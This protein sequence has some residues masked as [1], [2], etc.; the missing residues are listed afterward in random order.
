[1]LSAHAEKPEKAFGRIA[2]VALIALP[3]L[4]PFAEGPSVNA[5]QQLATWACVAVLSGLAPIHL[6]ARPLITWLAASALAVLL[7]HG[8]D[9]PLAAATVFALAMAGVAACVGAGMARA[10]SPA[11]WA[12]ALLAAGLLSAPL[13]LLQYYGLADVLVPWTT[14]PEP[15]QAYGNLRQRNQFASLISMALIAALWLH[16]VHGRRVRAALAPGALLLVVAA[17]AATSRTGLLVFRTPWSSSRLCWPIS[18]PHGCCPSWPV[19]R[20]KACWPACAMARRRPTA[21]CCYGAT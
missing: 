9:I 3:F 6:P 20:S 4:L 14:T 2:F 1:M 5:Q 12:W 11:P 15:G 13:G 19:P 17:A 21:G 10:G 8:H 18:Q 16:A 7:G